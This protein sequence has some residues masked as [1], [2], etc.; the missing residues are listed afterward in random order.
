MSTAAEKEEVMVIQEAADGSAVVELP[1]GLVPADENEEK[2]V[3]NESE[4]SDDGSDEADDEAREAEIA[5]GGSVN[6][7]A[8]ALREQKRLKR[9]RRKEYHRQV[10]QEKNLKLDML[11]RQNQQLLERL[12]VLERKSHGSDIAR[13]ESKIEEQQNRVAF[14][15]AKMAEATSTQNGELLASAQEMWFEAR[16]NVEALENL[17]KRAAQP[18]R[19]QPIQQ[20]NPALVNLAKQWM[21]NNR[22]YDPKGGDED[23]KIALAIDEQMAAEGWDATTPEFWRELDN[24]VARRLPHRYTED[25]DEKPNRRPRNVVT[26]SGREA[27]PPASSGNQFYLSREQINAIKE[28]G[29]WD[30]PRKRAKMIANYAQ[31]ARSQRNSG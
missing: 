29:M 16:R 24:R 13:L 3:K 25:A 20:Q 1:A 31:Y 18:Q 5:A 23:S 26:G 17:R 27:S 6:E 14:A 28:A 15:K 10:E 21:S 30:D 12:A 4:D 22:W 19:Q 8:E 11:S 7:D 2:P 9:L